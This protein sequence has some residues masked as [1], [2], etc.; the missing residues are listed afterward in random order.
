MTTRSDRRQPDFALMHAHE[1]ARLVRNAWRNSRNSRLAG[2][3]ERATR[4][5]RTRDCSAGGR[6]LDIATARGDVK[7]TLAALGWIEGRNL[8]IDYRP[9]SNDL[10]RIRATVA[11]VVGTAPLY[12]E[13]SLLPQTRVFEIG[14]RSTLNGG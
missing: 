7:K 5:P 4:H 14:I 1:T 12:S 2:G 3:S 13:A 9:L 10:D 8:R 6:K 11:E